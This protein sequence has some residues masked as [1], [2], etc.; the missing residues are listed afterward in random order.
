MHGLEHLTEEKKK[1]KKEDPE[2]STF[3]IFKAYASGG[4]EAVKEFITDYADTEKEKLFLREKA[5]LVASDFPTAVAAKPII[6]ALGELAT[7]RQGAYYGQNVEYGV[8]GL[9][10]LKEDN[11]TYRVE[12]APN[13]LDVF[14][15][16]KTPESEGLQETSIKPTSGYSKEDEWYD[17][18]PY[19]EFKWFMG[20]ETALMNF[21]R[22]VDRLKPGESISV[23]DTKG[24]DVLHHSSIDLGRTSWT[25]EKDKDGTTYLALADKWDFGGSTGA[26]GEV[27]DLIGAEKINFYGRFPVNDKSFVNNKDGRDENWDRYFKH[28]IGGNNE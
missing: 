12:D 20:E 2:V 6:T 26:W 14:L 17:V 1:T 10:R 25:V 3:N 8:E 28:V 5:R 19:I 24:V 21:Y 16:F 13:L 9:G 7:G 11:K 27:M 4:P 22:K 15:G 23:N 18:T